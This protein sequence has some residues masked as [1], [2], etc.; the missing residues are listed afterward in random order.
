MLC[1][2]IHVMNVKLYCGCECCLCLDIMVVHPM[3]GSQGA[4]RVETFIFGVIRVE[5]AWGPQETIH[6]YCGQLGWYGIC[7]F[8][9]VI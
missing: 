8:H 5:A 6:S 7:V 4:I 9:C 2:P 1:V 3:G